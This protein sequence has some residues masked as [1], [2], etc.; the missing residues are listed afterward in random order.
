MFPIQNKPAWLCKFAKTL[1]CAVHTAVFTSLVAIAL[2]RHGSITNPLKRMGHNPRLH[3]YILVIWGYSIFS[4]TP[5]IYIE[6]V[7]YMRNFTISSADGV[8]KTY[9]WHVCSPSKGSIQKMLTIIYFIMGVVLPLLIITAAYSK[10]TVYLWRKSRNRE[11]NKAALKSKGK[12]LRMLVLMVLG[13][14]VCLGIPQVKDVM[15]SFGF[16][17]QIFAL[18]ALVLQ[19]SSSVVNPIIYGFYSAEFKTGLRN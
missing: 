4:A 18:F 6:E 17:V 15:D 10:I 19:L 14:V 11:T 12:A 1:L 16:D 5:Q 13:F 9:L 2:D 3:L 8:N 7:R